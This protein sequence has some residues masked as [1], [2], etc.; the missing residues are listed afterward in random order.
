MKIVLSLPYALTSL[1]VVVAERIPFDVT[2]VPWRVGARHRRAAIRAI[3]S[4]AL[5][6]TH[7]PT[8]WRPGRTSLTPDERRLPRRSGQHLVI[9]T[10][11]APHELPGSLQLARATAR[12]LA[13]EYDGLLI[14]PL[15]RHSRA[16]LR[17]GG[18]GAGGLRSGRQ[19]AELVHP[20]PRHPPL[21]PFTPLG[22]H[23]T[24]KHRHIKASPEPPR[25]GAAPG[26]PWVGVGP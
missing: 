23:A 22:Q 15:A 9:S 8:P 5:L 11:A 20:P 13:R 2:A 6:V 19:L 18:G 21:P 1:F 26:L 16:H 12:A 7:H 25:A 10:T 24:P 14:D 4:P 3:G 17:E